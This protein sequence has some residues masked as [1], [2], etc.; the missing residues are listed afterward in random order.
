MNDNFNYECNYDQ[1]TMKVR[2]L[3]FLFSLSFFTR[4]TYF[5]TRDHKLNSQRSM[6]KI[7]KL[8]SSGRFASTCTCHV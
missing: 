2:D 4:Y 5:G 1:L 6:A 3:L 8:P 7:S